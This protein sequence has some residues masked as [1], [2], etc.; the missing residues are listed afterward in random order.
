MKK[1]NLIIVMLVIM[2]VMT[3]LTFGTTSNGEELIDRECNDVSTR[4]SSIHQMLCDL[5]VKTNIVDIT[6][7]IHAS[8][9]DRTKIVAYLQREEN[10]IWITVDSI[11][12][13]A[14]QQLCSFSES[15]STSTKYKFRVKL[16]GYVYNGSTLLEKVTWYAY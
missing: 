13:S 5:T 11:S 14:D 15:I 16:Y 3:N 2:L 12:K 10:D 1:T 9:G 7:M 8:T 6:A 4:Y